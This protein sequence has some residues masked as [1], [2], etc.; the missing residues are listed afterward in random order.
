M[1]YALTRLE[2]F[3]QSTTQHATQHNATQHVSAE[4][5]GQAS[6]EMGK[7][8]NERPSVCESHQNEACSDNIENEVQLSISRSMKEQYQQMLSELEGELGAG[9]RGQGGGVLGQVWQIP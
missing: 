8:E 6:D 2:S 3:V 1:I 7:R 9:V 5:K 4:A